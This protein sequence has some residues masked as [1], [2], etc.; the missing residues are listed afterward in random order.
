MCNEDNFDIQNITFFSFKNI[1]F[2]TKKEVI[3]IN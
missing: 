1:N 3:N 2:E